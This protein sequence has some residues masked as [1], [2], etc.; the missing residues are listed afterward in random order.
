V[1]AILLC[2]MLAACSR[3]PQGTPRPTLS[4]VTSVEAQTGLVPPNPACTC[5]SPESTPAPSKYEAECNERFAKCGDVHYAEYL[6]RTPGAPELDKVGTLLR[7]H[8]VE[9]MIYDATISFSQPATT[10]HVAHDSMMRV[11]IGDVIPTPRGR[12]RVVQVAR[13]FVEGWDDG[14]VTLHF[15]ETFPR[16]KPAW[17]YVSSG[18]P[19]HI[20]GVALTLMS[21]EHAKAAVVMID[22]GVKSTLELKKGDELRTSKG[23]Y[24]VVDVVDGI[25]GDALGWVTIDCSKS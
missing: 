5:N 4:P 14:R 15:L 6:A 1:R 23:K 3:E 21:T 7:T 9:S 18:A 2:S 10:E 12:A 8:M 24:R 17:V 25:V 16:E 19:S 11:H 22:A 13:S 20:D